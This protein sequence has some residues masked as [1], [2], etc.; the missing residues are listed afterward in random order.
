MPVSRP[1]RTEAHA[2]RDALIQQFADKGLTPVLS[3][4]GSVPS[5]DIELTF[6]K[7]QPGSVSAAVLT[8]A[9]RQRLEGA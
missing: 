8:E 1:P 3:T 9:G 2:Q 4:N 7:L 5:A 6:N